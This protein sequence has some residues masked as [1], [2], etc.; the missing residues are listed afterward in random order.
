MMDWHLAPG[1][2][3]IAEDDLHHD[4]VKFAVFTLIQIGSVVVAAAGV[5]AVP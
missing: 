1:L 4:G 5:M 3:V 2:T